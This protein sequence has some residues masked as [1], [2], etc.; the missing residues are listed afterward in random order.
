MRFGL[1]GHSCGNTA[2]VVFSPASECKYFVEGR[3]FAEA[4]EVHIGK[5]AG[6]APQFPPLPYVVN[7]CA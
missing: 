6:D 2:T 3:S 4:G 7:K 5:M 1:C